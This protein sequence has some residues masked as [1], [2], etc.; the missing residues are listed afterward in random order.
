M[1]G[2]D[3]WT[4]SFWFESFTSGP[5]TFSSIYRIE[6]HLLSLKRQLYEVILVSFTSIFRVANTQ[7]QELGPYEGRAA[8][9]MKCWMLNQHHDFLLSNNPTR[10]Q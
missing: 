3:L 8:I 9:S 2:H 1:K 6:K 7:G 10:K 4:F 5:Q